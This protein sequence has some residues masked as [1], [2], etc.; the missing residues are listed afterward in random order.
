MELVVDQLGQ[1]RPGQFGLS[2]VSLTKEVANCPGQ[3]VC[4]ARAGF[5]ADQTSETRPLE[6]F[7]S[8]IE[9]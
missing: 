9:G 5:L 2:G 8:L 7:L 3:L 4:A 1:L 6:G